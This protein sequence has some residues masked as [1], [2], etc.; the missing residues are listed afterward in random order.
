MHG[1]SCN[2][3]GPSIIKPTIFSILDINECEDANGG[4]EHNCTNLEGGYECT[5]LGELIVDIDGRSCVCFDG[6]ALN[7]NMT[8]EGW[9]IYIYI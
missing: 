3:S 6:F 5:C 2:L 1:Y 7:D 8:C 4:C 9:F